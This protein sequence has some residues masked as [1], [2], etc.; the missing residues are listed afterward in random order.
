MKRSSVGRL[1]AIALASL[2][3]VLLTPAV[4]LADEG[5]TLNIPY[6]GAGKVPISLIKIMLE[7]PTGTDLSTLQLSINEGM[8]PATVMSVPGAG[9]RPN[10]DIVTMLEATSA[11][12]PTVYIRYTPKSMWTS[13]DPGTDRCNANGAALPQNVSMTLSGPTVSTYRMNTYTV[14]RDLDLTA[15]VDE[16]GPC[17]FPSRRIKSNAAS[18][19]P[20]P[21]GTALDPAKFKGRLPLDVVLVLDKSG[22]MFS[23]PDGAPAGSP[24]KWN[25]LNDTIQQFVD[26][27]TQADDGGPLSVG[28]S[29]SADATQD[30]LAVVFFSTSATVADLDSDPANPPVVVFVK[31]GTDGTTNWL[32]VKTVVGTTSPGGSTAMGQGLKE[33]IDKYLNDALTA[34]DTKNDATIILMT[35]ALQNVAPLIT[36]NGVTGNMELAPLSGPGLC[37][38][39]VI[40]SCHVPVQT[41]GFTTEGSEVDKLLNNI[42][43]QTSGHSIVRG[44]AMGAATAFA[45][46][47]VQSL[48]GNTLALLS[49]T[50]STLPAGTDASAP[51]PFLL[52]GSVRRATFV[53]GWVGG[54]Q[55]Q[56]LDLEIT[57]PD[58]KV[59]AP[60]L[61]NNGNA[62]TVQSIDLPKSG[63]TGNWSVKVLRKTVGKAALPKPESPNASADLW[64]GDVLRRDR[65][66]SETSHAPAPT[67]ARTQTQTPQSPP[68]PYHLSIYSVEGKLDY[69]LSF[70]SLD[71]GTGDAMRLAADVS[72]EG[73]SL[74]NLP[75]S[76]IK[77][78]IER[79]PK[80]LGTILHDTGVQG[81]VLTTETAQGGDS[82]TPYDRKLAELAKNGALA[83]SKPKELGDE[84]FLVDNGDASSGDKR[85][86]DGLYTARF[87][88]TSRPGLY[89][90][91][92]TMDWD[93]PRT[94]RIHRIETIER[95]VK[96]NSDTSASKVTVT[97]LGQ[98]AYDIK[99]IPLDKF[100]NYFG[101][102]N[103]NPVTVK[104]TGGG[105]VAGINDPAQTGEYIVHLENVPAGADPHIVIVVDGRTI[106]DTPLSGLPGGG[107]TTVTPGGP[108]TKFA[109]FFHFGAAFPH[110]NFNNAFDPG[111]SFNG[112]LEYAV[113]D[114]FSV[115]G[116][117]GAHHFENSLI[118]GNN[119][120]LFQF[121]GNGKFY[122]TPPGSVRPW[123]NFGIG[124]YKFD[125]GSTRFG[126]NVGT[127]L[128]FNLTPKFALEAAYNFHAVSTTGAS[129]TYSTLQG[130][131]RFR[132]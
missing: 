118:G 41:F 122:L 5:F 87:A 93:D 52:D 124:A 102:S 22:S 35:D 21:S 92:I 85:A 109:V 46:L 76:A 45:D 28:G 96:V 111:F 121:S 27:W 117:F 58:G 108:T 6:R 130:G 84:F 48:K 61:T 57:G 19:G 110:G 91:N 34:T 25:I 18:V 106:R 69:R 114:Y 75:N 7:F 43:T 97:N 38:S 56:R 3:V 2:V 44:D 64:P 68:F 33:G 65:P 60:V 107:G 11:T 13:I 16:K 83:E 36:E 115:E 128:Q 77:L 94:G 105:D 51:V 127:G 17:D 119:V 29:F 86:N 88:D 89:R 113:T 67:G 24:S 62:S 104:V 20:P 98:G 59:V 4:G 50:R 70:P 26:L 79:P 10:G 39:S 125:P 1:T 82:T 37:I 47:L 14:P 66:Q 80:G 55:S 31:R 72:Y 120:D 131:F 95:V 90:F 53:L 74:T 116:I 73:K 54:S 40:S 132:F 112:G 63:P 71:E 123:V 103:A 78:K 32:P 101:P 49:R 9:T 126:G 100:G 8:G 129:T 30:R 23:A 12:V 81:G 15:G 42:S 99:V